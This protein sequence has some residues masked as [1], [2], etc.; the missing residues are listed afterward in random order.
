LWFFV[1]DFDTLGSPMRAAAVF[2]LG[3]SQKA[4]QTFQQNKS[5]DWRIGLPATGD[6][7][8][9]VLVFGGDGTLHRHLSEIVK[10][11]VPL[12]MVPVGSG[13]DFARALRLRR[14]RDSLAA[15]RQF[16]EDRNNIHTIDLGVITDLTS[17]EST[18]A[19]QSTYFAT[20][21]GVG[22][23]SEVTRR[24]NNLPRWLRANGGYALSLAPVIL[25]FA[26]FRMKILILDAAEQ[27]IARSDQTTLLATFANTGFYGG[28]M[29]IAPEAQPDDG[30]L[31]VCLIG[32][33]NPFKLA[34][35]F[36]AVYFG[37]HLRV[38]EVQYFRSARIRIQTESPMDIYADGEF[39]CQTPAEIGIQSR[40]LKVITPY[41]G[42]KL[43]SCLNDAPTHYSGS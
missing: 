39:V 35:L 19:Q 17:G 34:C 2:G 11:A 13:N 42:A 6:Q 28:G 32:G 27:W 36:P 7:T 31:D 30:K 22:L 3:C 12:L 23:D 41:H 16:L 9:V 14:R 33:M 5:I 21:A 38:R 10:L 26:P 20:V 8:D 43:A 24:A 37:Q 29:K 25:R 18:A 15:W 4:L 40:A 1:L